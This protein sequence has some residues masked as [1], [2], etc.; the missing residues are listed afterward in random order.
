MER[1]KEIRQILKLTRT[2]FSELY[3]I[4]YNTLAQWERGERSAPGYLI[5]LIEENIKLKQR[6]TQI[7]IDKRYLLCA[8][9]TPMHWVTCEEDKHKSYSTRHGKCTNTV[10]ECTK[11]ET[12]ETN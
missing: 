11:I 7:D 6:R 8:N 12:I 5:K 10:W 1:I 3:D 2:E 9:N 4:P